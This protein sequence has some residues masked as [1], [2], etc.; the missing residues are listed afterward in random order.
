MTKI[1]VALHIVGPTTDVAKVAPTANVAKWV[2]HLM[3][4]MWDPLMTC[5]SRDH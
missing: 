2:S 3:W 4:Q 1:S 5:Q